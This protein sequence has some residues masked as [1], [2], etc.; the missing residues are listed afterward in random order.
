[1]CIEAAK[2][3]GYTGVGIEV[4]SLTCLCIWSPFTLQSDVRIQ[5]NP[6]LVALSYYNAWKAG[7]CTVPVEV[8][9]GAPSSTVLSQLTFQMQDFWSVPLST[10][11]VITVFGV[12]SIMERLEAK[13]TEEAQK[14]L[15]VVCYR[16][17]LPTKEPVYSRD[18]LFIYR[19]DK[20]AASAKVEGR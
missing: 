17:P 13:L 20:K 4:R 8:G 10:F 9:A 2:H 5:L 1:L 14:P 19:F 15:Y 7:R 16:F 6:V 3:F 12:R 11:D 18:E